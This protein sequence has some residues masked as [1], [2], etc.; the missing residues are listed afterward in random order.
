MQ[1]LLKN[2]LVAVLCFGVLV[3]EPKKPVKTGS[4]KPAKPV[5]DSVRVF[6]HQ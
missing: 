2:L 6:V 4:V 5:S 3:P 1:K